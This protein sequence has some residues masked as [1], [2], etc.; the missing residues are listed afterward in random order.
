M[1]TGPGGVASIFMDGGKSNYTKVLLDGIPMNDPG[2]A[3]D[4]SNIT[5]DSV[6]KVEVVHGAQ[7]ALAGSD[8]MAGTI[9]MFSHRGSTQT[10]EV[11]VESEGGSFDT[12]RGTAQVSGL[13]GRFD[14]S[15]AGAFLQTNG[16]GPNDIFVDRTLSA[17]FGLR[18][19]KHD[20]L[21]F[22]VRNI[23]SFAGEP[24]QTL[25]EPPAI[26]QSNTLHNLSLGA[27]WNFS[28]GTHWQHQV[29]VSETDIHEVYQDPLNNF[30]VFSDFSYYDANQYNRV[31]AQAQ[32]SY[33]IRQAAM[34]AGYWYEV[35][36]GFPGD[37]EGVH[38][39]RNNQAGFLDGRWQ[40]VGR[41]TVNAGVR[42]EDNYDFGTRAVPRAGA[43]YTLRYGRNFWGETRLRFIYGQGIKA[44]AFDQLFGSN[45]C[46]LGNPALLPEQSQTINAG[47]E[48]ELDNSRVV[49][50]A[51]YF[52]NRFTNIVSFASTAPTTICP[53][54]AGQYFN[55]DLAR[56]GGAH[57]RFESKI[58]RHVNLSGNYSYDDSRVIAA[59]NASDPTETP[60]NRLFL[61]P[62]NSGN[63]IL[64]GSFGRFQ[65]NI[66]AIFVG[67]RTD[68]DFLGLGLTS[69]PGY[70]RVDLAASYR[71]SHNVNVIA[72]VQNLLNNHYQDAL[73]YPS[74][75]IGAYGGV[76]LNFGGDR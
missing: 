75:G 46:D 21:R 8:A 4:F 64:N 13:A 36:N 27:T 65:G 24:G 48:Q 73:G 71:I 53:F 33:V 50:S 26:G 22:T 29:F 69:L 54:G 32:S 40:P 7:S 55:T 58:A 37:L 30:P 60:G 38:A 34:T 20:T 12:W 42:I 39:R 3:M 70:G 6:D 11:I 28:T 19:S 66:S 9:S 68:S 44:P 74:L 76:R 10:P 15:V 17:N 61:Q 41:L 16:Q 5:L 52:Y 47:V 45:P 59:P 62:V 23:L 1:Q 67:R 2:G 25:L 18:V 35:E 72:R 49:V 31:D 56:A 63:L 57:L 51:D 43:S 14:Y